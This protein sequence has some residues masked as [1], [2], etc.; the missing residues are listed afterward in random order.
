MEQWIEAREMRE[1]TYAVVMH[2]TQR[3]THH[4]VVYSAT[5]LARM[6]LSDADG[7][8]LVET[9]VGLLAER[10]D[11]VEHDLDLDWMVHEDADFLIA[12]RERLVE[13][14]TV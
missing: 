3:T 9:A 2:R 7:R 1:G 13:S 4:L 6:G 12:L 10:E 5:F 8:R 14:T 11:E